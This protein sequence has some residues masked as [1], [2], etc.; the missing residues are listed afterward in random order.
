MKRILMAMVLC[1]VCT[2]GITSCGNKE[3]P[4]VPE[5]VASYEAKIDTSEIL[6]SRQP[7]R[8]SLSQYLTFD[9]GDE[10]SETTKILHKELKFNVKKDVNFYPSI[11]QF[12]QDTLQNLFLINVTYYGD[13]WKFLDRGEIMVGD[14]K[15]DL[16]LLDNSTDVMS[17]GYVWEACA[18]GI[19]YR[20]LYLITDVEKVSFKIYGSKGN[21]K[22]EFVKNELD[23]FKT[24]VQYYE[25]YRTDNLKY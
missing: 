12:K 9:E 21:V 11:L 2:F 20:S 18:F 6:K 13:D 10:F 22:Y 7:I 15:F 17:G 1:L 23:N 19:P 3:T 5:N 4:G 24:L 16:V 8:D 14:K 25:T